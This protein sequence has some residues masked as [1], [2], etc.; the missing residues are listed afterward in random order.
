MGKLLN[1]VQVRSGEHP[2]NSFKRRVSP[3]FRSFCALPPLVQVS[4][5]LTT[6][7]ICFDYIDRY[8]F[9]HM[10]RFFGRNAGL[11]NLQEALCKFS[12]V[13]LLVSLSNRGALLC[14]F[15]L[16]SLIDKDDAL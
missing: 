5:D 8:I 9:R 3:L 12:H 16:S 10:L 11:G 15:C 2:R 6:D 1:L 13:F 7:L 4:K 14:I